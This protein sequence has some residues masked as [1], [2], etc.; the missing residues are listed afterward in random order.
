ML[1]KCVNTKCDSK[2]LYMREG[3]MFSVYDRRLHPRAVEHYWVC[4]TCKEKLFY[5]K[6]PAKIYYL[7]ELYLKMTG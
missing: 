4:D 1:S 2:F 7:D 3:K 6:A 5:P